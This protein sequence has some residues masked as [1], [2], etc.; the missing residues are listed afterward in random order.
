MASRRW[1]ALLGSLIL[2]GCSL[3]PSADFVA[4][5]GKDPATVSITIVY[6]YGTVQFC[7]TNIS[8]G[9]VSCSNNGIAV[10]STPPAQAVGVQLV[11]IK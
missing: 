3:S 10:E 7:R 5:L 1:L 8:N 4:A 11:P 9:K 6:P 2:S